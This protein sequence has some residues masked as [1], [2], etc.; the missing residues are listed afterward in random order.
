LVFCHS[1]PRDTQVHLSLLF[2]Q[3]ERGDRP[4]EQILG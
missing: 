1:L 4:L 3:F 2:V